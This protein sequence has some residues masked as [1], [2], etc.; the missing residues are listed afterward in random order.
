MENTW[1]E[2]KKDLDLTPEMEEEIRFEE[3]IIR[4]VIESREKCGLTQKQLA[5]L[6]G[7]KQPVIARLEKATHSPQMD[8]LLRIL[9]PMGYTLK[10]VPI[11][12]AP[13]Q[14]KEQ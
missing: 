11:E 13:D 12:T 9:R 1:N 3:D 2:L 5:E 8:S 10:V 14:L 6:S 7:V 4:A